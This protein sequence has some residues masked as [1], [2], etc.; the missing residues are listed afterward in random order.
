M[1]PDYIPI[2]GVDVTPSKSSSNSKSLSFLSKFLIHQIETSKNV[3]YDNIGQELNISGISWR[4]LANKIYLINDTFFVIDTAQNFR[5]IVHVDDIDISPHNQVLTKAVLVDVIKEFEK[6]GYQMNK[7]SFAKEKVKFSLFAQTIPGFR[8][9]ESP[10]IIV[11]I[12]AKILTCAIDEI[13]V[14]LQKIK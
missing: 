2:S 8:P 1:D 9:Q 6:L 14:T 13:T 10:K 11:K 5:Y 12:R 4:I 7:F 3:T